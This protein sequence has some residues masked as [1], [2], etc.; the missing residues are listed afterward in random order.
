EAVAAAGRVD[1]DDL[2]GLLGQVQERVWQARRQI[3]E[4]PALERV[5]LVP[6]PDLE[7]PAEDVDRLFLPA[8]AVQRRTAMRW[9]LDDE[10]VEC[11]AGVV[12]R[13]LEHEIAPR[14]GLKAQPLVRRQDLGCADD[15]RHGGLPR[16][17]VGYLRSANIRESI[18][19]SQITCP[20][21]T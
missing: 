14:P 20:S 17:R 2:G 3:G 5:Q 7:A 18:C 11:A 12:A 8:G 1:D 4:A 15:R 10:V 9:D 19:T 13:E 21:R 16:A 6:D